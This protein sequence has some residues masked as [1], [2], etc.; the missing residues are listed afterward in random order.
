LRVIP[1]F[2]VAPNCSNC[3]AM[4]LNRKEDYPDCPG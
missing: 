2:R 4:R 1:I 3:S